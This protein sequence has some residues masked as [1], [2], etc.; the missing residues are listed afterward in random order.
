MIDYYKDDVDKEWG[1]LANHIKR[2]YIEHKGI[3]SWYI[4][5]R[6]Y[7]SELELYKAATTVLA[8]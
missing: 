6:R 7:H 5:V 2:T 1:D 3:A 8:E 4:L